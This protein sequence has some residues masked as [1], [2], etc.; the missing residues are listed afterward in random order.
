MILI[1]IYELGW[2]NFDGALGILHLIRSVELVFWPGGNPDL[3]AKDPGE[4]RGMCSARSR[5][6][7]EFTGSAL[8]PISLV[9]G[10]ITSIPKWH[11]ICW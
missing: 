5:K 3:L 2:V 6:L 11:L 1:A 9:V 10:C 4:Y 7:R 8:L